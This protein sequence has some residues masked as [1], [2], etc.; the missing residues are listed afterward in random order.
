MN[1]KLTA[2]MERYLVGIYR[3]TSEGKIVRTGELVKFFNVAPGTVTNTVRRLKKEGLV[4]HHPYKGIR[5]T[6]K[7]LKK[8]LNAANKYEVLER[9]L[10]DVLRVEKVLA[11]QL[12]FSIGYH[13]PDDVVAK[14]G[15]L[16]SKA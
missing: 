13:V 2:S 7:G 9:F 10:T 5:L 6:E 16:L 1:E 8:A 3:L 4:I 15:K 14:I 11:R 12:T